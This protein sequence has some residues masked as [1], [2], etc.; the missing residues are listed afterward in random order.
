M[1]DRIDGIGSFAEDGFAHVI[2]AIGLDNR[3]PTAAELQKM[4]DITRREMEAGAWG[5]YSG[6]RA[7]RV[8]RK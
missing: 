6:V 4:K 7:G 8:L 3:Q 1:D 2:D 5:I